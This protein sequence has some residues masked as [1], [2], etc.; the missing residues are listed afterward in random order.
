MPI[1]WPNILFEVFL[2]VELC[3]EGAT[4][5]VVIITGVEEI[6]LSTFFER[7]VTPIG[8][9]C[10]AKLCLAVVYHPCKGARRVILW[11]QK[12]VLGGHWQIGQK[13]QMLW[14]NLISNR[15]FIEEDVH[16]SRVL[17]QGLHHPL[18]IQPS[19][20]RRWFWE[21]VESLEM[22]H[23]ASKGKRMVPESKSF[24]YVWELALFAALLIKERPT[25]FLRSSVVVVFSVHYGNRWA[26]LQE[27]GTCGQSDTLLPN[28][29][30]F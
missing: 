11:V 20:L 24:V 10:V 15:Q 13:F 5:E 3:G 28:H 4:L 30:C 18:N 21:I 2:T 1:R 26:L 25:A 27:F 8:S 23:G 6:L 9:T 19:A 16:R 22:P 29:D 7:I 17:P 14:L 12:V